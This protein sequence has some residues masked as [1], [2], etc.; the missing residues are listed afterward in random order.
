[1][2]GFTVWL[3][4]SINA[5]LVR[6]ARSVNRPLLQNTDRRAVFERLDAER[7]PFYKESAHLWLEA[8]TMDVNTVAVRVCEEAEKFF[9]AF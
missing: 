1:M 3:N 4:V 2:L 9:A 7:R 8:S 6:T 5:L